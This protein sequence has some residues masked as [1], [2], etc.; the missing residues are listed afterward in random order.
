[1]GHVDLEGQAPYD[2]TLHVEVTY[3]PVYDRVY[4]SVLWQLQED[5]SLEGTIYG[6]VEGADRGSRQEPFPFTLATMTAAP[7]AGSG[8]VSGPPTRR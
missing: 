2:G 7:P 6:G 3:P 5:R 1:M 8:G 4:Q